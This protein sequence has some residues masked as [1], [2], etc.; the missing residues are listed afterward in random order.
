MQRLA[1]RHQVIALGEHLA[2]SLTHY[3]DNVSLGF[4]SLIKEKQIVSEKCF[5]ES[6]T[7]ELLTVCRISQEK[8]IEW[9]LRAIA[10]L[11]QLGILVNYTVVGDGPDLKR[12]LLLVDELGV[13][14]EVRFVGAKPYSEIVNYYQV[15][16]IFIL[17]SYTEGVAKVLLE[18]MANRLPIVATKVGGT[19]WLLGHGDRG[20][21]VEF[22]N[23]HAIA[24]A[25]LKFQD[26]HDF[27]LR[28]LSNATNFIMQNTIEASANFILN[29]VAIEMGISR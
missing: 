28:S 24:E 22:G 21:L 20:T 29:T 17:P 14:S 1:K 12:L 26:D 3:G 11:K 19:P 6:G 27:R 9:A 13:G 23:H 25:V 16:D 7:L 2:E 8:G 15:A 10:L 18:A 4:T 5:H